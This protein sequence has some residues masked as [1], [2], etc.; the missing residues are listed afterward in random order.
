V[1]GCLIIKKPFSILRK[2]LL[3]AYLIAYVLQAS[4]LSFNRQENRL[5]L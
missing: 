3:I 2:R 5:N 1:F 4:L